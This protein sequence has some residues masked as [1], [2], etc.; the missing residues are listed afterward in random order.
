MSN[1]IWN[2][3]WGGSEG[4]GGVSL[5]SAPTGPGGVVNVPFKMA[6]LTPLSVVGEGAPLGTGFASVLQ[7]YTIPLSMLNNRI[8]TF[9]LMYSMVAS[10]SIRSLSWVAVKA[11]NTRQS[12]FDIYPASTALH[13]SSRAVARCQNNQLSMLT[14]NNISNPYTSST[15]EPTIS[16]SLAGLTE[17]TIHIVNRFAEGTS[18]TLLLSS[19]EVS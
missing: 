14:L 11:D 7:T 8:I 19:M 2:Q 1:L 3:G 18:G 5:P 16:I 10:T 4:S 12:I 17:V 6:H 9:E 15:S 13:S